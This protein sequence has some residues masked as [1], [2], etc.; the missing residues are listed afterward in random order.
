MAAPRLKF[1]PPLAQG[2]LIQ[3]Y[4]R[5]LADIQTSSGSLTIHCPNTGAMTHCAEPGFGVYYSASAN[6]K[7]KYPN[8]WEL[9]RNG[10]GEYICVNTQRANQLLKL[11]LDAGGLPDFYDFDSY[12]AEVSIGNSRLDFMLIQNAK[13]PLYIEVK[14]V[15]LNDKGLGLFPDAV[16]LR[17]Q[18]HLEELIQLVNSGIPSCLF[19]AVMHTGIT[20]VSPASTI[21]PEYSRLLK[22]ASAS[23]V[24]VVAYRAQLSHT[25]MSWDCQIPVIL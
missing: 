20:H 19:F 6:P 3:R 9:A 18:R 24:K 15:T 17:G 21:D 23:G 12:Q 7:R 16:T 1:A 4:K 13:P 5:F 11:Q 10:S 8:T 2:I 25:G 22:L 14:S